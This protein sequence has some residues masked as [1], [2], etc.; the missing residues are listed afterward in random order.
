MS[1]KKDIVLKGAHKGDLLKE[2]T[3]SFL[4]SGNPSALLTYLTQGVKE[5]CEEYIPYGEQGVEDVAFMRAF[6]EELA[7]MAKVYTEREEAFFGTEVRK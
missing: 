3:R 7:H 5:Y 4:H 2:V 6:A 1:D